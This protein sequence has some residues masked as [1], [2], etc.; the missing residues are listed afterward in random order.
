[1]AE[2]Q[3]Y[4]LQSDPW[5]SQDPVSDYVAKASIPEPFDYRKS[6]DTHHRCEHLRLCGHFWEHIHVLAS[7]ETLVIERARHMR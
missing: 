2:H 6:V 4:Y 7:P 3:Q 5:V 1:V